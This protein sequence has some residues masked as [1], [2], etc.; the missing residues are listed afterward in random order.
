L[1]WELTDIRPVLCDQKVVAARGIYQVELDD[2]L[3]TSGTRKQ[4]KEGRES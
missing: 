3:L 2:V 4:E 1:A